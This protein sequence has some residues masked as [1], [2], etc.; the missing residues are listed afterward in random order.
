MARFNNRAGGAVNDSYCACVMPPTNSDGE[1]VGFDAIAT[2]PPVFASST[3][4]EP[5]GAL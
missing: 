5:P 4:T 3:I 2:T 1:Y